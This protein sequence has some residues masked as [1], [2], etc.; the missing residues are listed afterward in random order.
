MQG[1]PGRSRTRWITAL[2]LTLVAAG[3]A[4]LLVGGPSGQ[5]GAAT[6]PK[7]TPM[8]YLAMGDSLGAGVGASPASDQYV[9][10]VY[11][12]VL[13]RF[14]TLQLDNLSCGGATTASV[15][16]GPGCSYSTGTQLGDAEAFLRAHPKHVP[17]V[18]I[19]IG[20]NDVDGCQVGESLSP[21]CIQSGLQA[22]TTQLPTIL[23]GLEAAYP[24][25]AV[26]GMDYY[27]PFLGE[28]LL[29]AGGQAVAEQSE[30]L[31][32]SL[33]TLL[34]QLY[35]A[36][37]AST[38]DPASLFAVTDFSP[39]G[40]YLGVTEPQ[41]VANACNWTLFCSD[42][43]NIHADDTGHA[44]LAEAFAG[45]LGGVSVTTATLPPGAVKAGY[46]A[47]LSASGGHPAYRWSVA[48]GSPALPSGL[49]LRSDGTLVGKPKVAGTYSFTVQVTDTKLAI[50]AP[51][52]VH[53]A[54]RVLSLTIDPPPAG[55]A[56]G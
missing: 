29:G 30:Q 18:T 43:G 33:N 45:V 37:G 22:I 55:T 47:A 6:T 16:D 41:N 10:L 4:A 9:D 44:L 23:G 17:I 49:R 15:I 26:Y 35:S 27:D 32:V 51:P 2:V 28:W 52:P 11:Q 13:S 46:A 53:Q 24:G 31:V 42:D 12:H 21:A 25:V 14:P 54:T 48:A 8:Y 40:S 36:A 3:P 7:S 50:T 39:T 5:A 34:A 56:K 1:P 20:A 19:D 38:A